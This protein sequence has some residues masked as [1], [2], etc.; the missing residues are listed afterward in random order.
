MNRPFHHSQLVRVPLGQKYKLAFD[1]PNHSTTTHSF[2]LGTG[3]KKRK[4]N[5]NNLWHA[6]VP[7]RLVVGKR[8]DKSTTLSHLLGLIHSHLE[9]FKSKSL[10]ILKRKKN[11]LYQLSTIICFAQ[12]YFCKNEHDS[13]CLKNT[14]WNAGICLTR[15]DQAGSTNAWIRIGSQQRDP[16]QC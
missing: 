14:S 2:N 10:F 15:Q 12:F 7:A 11:P 6:R 8:V 1:R 5:K 9:Q 16:L 3:N 4:K 13:R